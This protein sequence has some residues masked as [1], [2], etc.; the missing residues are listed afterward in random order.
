M[1]VF[2]PATNRQICQSAPSPLEKLEKL[3]QLRALEDGM[4]ITAHVVDTAPGGI[5]T[6]KIWCGA[7]AFKKGPRPSFR[8]QRIINSMTD[9]IIT[10][11]D[12]CL[13]GAARGVFAH[14]L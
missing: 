2:L 12:N 11:N 5:D 9:S 13:S 3:E 7:P 6:S 14:G 10:R 8:D 4:V 1:S